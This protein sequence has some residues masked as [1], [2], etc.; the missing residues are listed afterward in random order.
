LLPFAAIA[1]VVLGAPTLGIAGRTTPG[2]SLRAQNV[3]LQARSHSTVLEL[4][5]L[6]QRLSSARTHLSQLH[7]V[8]TTLRAQRAGL[9]QQLRIAQRGRQIAQRRLA[10]R[11][12]LLYEQGNVEPL[13]VLF[14]AKNLEDA[15]S[16]LD[17]LNRMTVQSGDVL[18]QLTA[19]RTALT[20]ASARL[21]EREAATAAAAARA[22][23][24]AASLAATRA[25]R[26]A[27]LHSVSAQ[28][29]LNDA[30]ISSLVA[31]AH[32]AQVRS[33][34]VV[35]AT[36]TDAAALVVPSAVAAITRTTGERTIK[37]LATGYSLAGTT[38]TGLHVGW[39]VAAVDPSVI[40]LGARLTVPGYGAAIAADTGGAVVGA[41]IDLW[42]PTVKQA[43]AW[44]RRTVTIVIS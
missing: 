35:R 42:F 44:G 10:A 27:F 31:Q 5:S 40:P 7:S 23:E 26:E 24:E 43:N 33:A 12:R 9:E 13:E 3:E 19:A 20:R 29:R 37:V 2:S 30:Q 17:N 4:Y 15:L 36:A 41:V 11:L 38:A 6:D 18:R 28:R 22:H 1:L 39:G 21:G 14:G 32:A 25:S 16:S 34:K 8:A